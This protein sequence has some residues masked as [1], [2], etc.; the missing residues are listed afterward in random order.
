[1]TMENS[2]NEETRSTVD[3]SQPSLANPSRRRFNRVGAGASAVVMTLASRSVLAADALCKS[4]SGHDSM[5]PSMNPNKIPNSCAGVSP[6][7]WLSRRQWPVDK[8][9]LFSS[10][11]GNSGGLYADAPAALSTSSAANNTGNTS[12][13][14]VVNSSNSASINGLLLNDATLVQAMSGTATPVIVKNLL[15]AWLNALQGYNTFPT[16][17]QVI[18]IFKEWQQKTY[19]EVR[20]G[21]KWYEKEINDYLATTG[22]TDKKS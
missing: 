1:M 14:T 19:Y 18:H 11:F 2:G 21:V 9:A 15:A 20:A 8:N 16:T 12:D 13:K 10:S 6:S 22:S 3:N 17:D 4:P 7:Q 5:A